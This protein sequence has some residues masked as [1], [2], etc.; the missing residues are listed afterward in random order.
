MVR[1]I[2]PP[3]FGFRQPMVHR[4]IEIVV[5]HEPI[6]QMD[7]ARLVLSEVNGGYDQE[8]TRGEEYQRKIEH[9]LF[10]IPL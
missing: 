9:E 10:F 1:K 2:R 3:A 6:A 4:I 7:A 8:K 5:R